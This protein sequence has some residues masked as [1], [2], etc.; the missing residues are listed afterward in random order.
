M[1]YKSIFSVLKNEENGALKTYFLRT[2]RGLETLTFALSGSCTFVFATCCVEFVVQSNVGLTAIVP[3][4]YACF[5]VIRVKYDVISSAVEEVVYAYSNGK[6][7]V[8]ER[9]SY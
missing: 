8:Q 2:C 1:N 3:F 7:V 4:V 5:K 6:A 9:F